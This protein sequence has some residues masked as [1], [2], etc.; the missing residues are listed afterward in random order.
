[1]AYVPATAV[2][3]AR[4]ERGRDAQLH[5]RYAH[6]NQFGR[7]VVIWRRLAVQPARADRA[8]IFRPAPLR[9]GNALGG[10]EKPPRYHR[11][12]YW[13]RSWLNRKTC[14]QPNRNLRIS[15]RH[16][17]ETVDHRR[18]MLQHERPALGHDHQEL[19]RL[20]PVVQP[21]RLPGG[22]A[23]HRLRLAIQHRRVRSRGHRH[24]GAILLSRWW[25][26]RPRP[27]TSHPHQ[28]ARLGGHHD[29]MKEMWAKPVRHMYSRVFPCV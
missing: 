12:L 11:I 17:R 25:P 19:R 20:W 15:V 18:S 26:G 5:R 14:C 2:S 21:D 24:Q 4:S 13:G 29:R 9:V 27:Q 3:E 23:E 22:T 7:R 6:I 8:D 16:Q 28:C 10:D 1:M